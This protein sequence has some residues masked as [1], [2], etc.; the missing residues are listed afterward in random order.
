VLT[1]LV[2]LLIGLTTSFADLAA[3]AGPIVWGIVAIVAGRIVVVYGLLGGLR[4][5]AQRVRML[6]PKTSEWAHMG[7][8]PLGWLHVIFWSGLRGAVA[9]AL[10]LALP[11]NVPDRALLQGTIF[12]IVLFTLLVQGTTAG[13]VIAWAGGETDGGAPAPPGS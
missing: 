7:R 3:A 12:G 10:A 1:A 6:A 13:R 2:F 8:M 11:L 4:L 9:F 5:L